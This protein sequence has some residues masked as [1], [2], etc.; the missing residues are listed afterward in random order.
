MGTGDVIEFAGSISQDIFKKAY[1]LHFRRRTG[2]LVVIAIG[3]I[4]LLIVSAVSGRYDSVL[5]LVA[6]GTIGVLIGIVAF[7][8]KVNREFKKSPYI[9]TPRRGTITREK[10]HV[11]TSLGQSDLPWSTFV[12]V[13]ANDNLVLLYLGPSAFQILAKEFFASHD[14]WLNVRA[15]AMES[16][17]AK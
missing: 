12:K 1:Y 13:D 10:L 11:E 5:I 4:L 3:L 14:D 9:R 2:P 15:M 7:R 8:R 17:V 16:V 6:S